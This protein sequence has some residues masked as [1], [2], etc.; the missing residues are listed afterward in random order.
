MKIC[1][2]FFLLSIVL[3]GFSQAHSPT[4]D[5]NLSYNWFVSLNGGVQMSGIKDEDFIPQNIAPA[6]S[7][8]TGLWFTSEIAL[9]FGYKGFYF[10]TIA[11]KDKHH[12]N[13]YFGEVLLNVN[14][15][16]KGLQNRKNT[17]SVLFHPG[18]GLFYNVYYHRP[19]ICAHIGVINQYEI[20]KKI[21]V[22]ADISFIMG[23]D[24]YQ[25]NDDIL[26]SC[27]FGLNYSFK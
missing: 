3:V 6:F 14:N 8:A 26:P 25:G 10:N 21:S 23:W 11:D 27:V 24:I 15:L 20:S 4:K 22:F 13:Y 5:S 7:L 18:A 12:Y 19:N 9:N 2:S 16:I 17:W 1:L